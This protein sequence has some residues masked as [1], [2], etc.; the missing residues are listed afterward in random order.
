MDS[1]KK[2]TLDLIEASVGELSVRGR[3]RQLLLVAR[4]Y[5][6]EDEL[7]EVRRILRTVE[8]KFYEML[9]E[10]AASDFDVRMAIATFIEKL[11][12]D[13]ILWAAQPKAVS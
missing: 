3:G 10:V 12:M 7:V 8:D 13:W 1:V 5:A 6:E 2:R 4:D 9:P 11:G